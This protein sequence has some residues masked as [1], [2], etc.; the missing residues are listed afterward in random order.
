MPLSQEFGAGQGVLSVL[1]W[2]HENDS[3]ASYPGGA[4]Y[5]AGTDPSHALGGRGA[6]AESSGEACVLGR[7]RQNAGAQGCSPRC[8]PAHAREV[9]Y[10]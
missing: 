5:G 6:D 9:R 7:C 4:G 8:P 2:C 3:A 10:Q 1:E